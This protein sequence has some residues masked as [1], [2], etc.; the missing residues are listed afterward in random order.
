MTV[1]AGSEFVSPVSDVSWEVGNEVDIPNDKVVITEKVFEELLMLFRMRK[2]LLT[3]ETLHIRI[4]L[5]SVDWRRGRGKP[6]RLQ[7]AWSRT[8]PYW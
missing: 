4:T 3:Q 5:E 8:G 1:R 7:D 2:Y 6:Q